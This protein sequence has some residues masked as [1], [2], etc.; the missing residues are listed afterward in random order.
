[1]QRSAAGAL[2]ASGNRFGKAAPKRGIL[3]VGQHATRYVPLG[4]PPQPM[5]VAVV[6]LNPGD[7]RGP[8]ALR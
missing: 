8:A 5:A 6:W 3:G 7:R 1:L 4:R 2:C